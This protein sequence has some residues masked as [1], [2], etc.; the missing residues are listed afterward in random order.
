VGCMPTDKK[1]HLDIIMPFLNEHFTCGLQRPHTDFFN[2]LHDWPLHFP[3]LFYKNAP[4]EKG[5]A[6]WHG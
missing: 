5:P 2:H 4:V 1:R 3:R 6:D